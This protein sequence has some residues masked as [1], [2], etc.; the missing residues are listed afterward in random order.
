MANDEVKELPEE[1][2]GSPKKG[3]SRSFKIG[4]FAVIFIIAYILIHS[5]GPSMTVLD[6][7]TNQKFTIEKSTIEYSTPD[8]AMTVGITKTSQ[9]NGQK[10]YIAILPAANPI[11]SISFSWNPNGWNTQNYDP[12]NGVINWYSK[13]PGAQ[14]QPRDYNNGDFGGAKGTVPTQ[15]GDEYVCIFMP[16]KYL[17]VMIS[18][19]N[20][21]L[22]NDLIDSISIDGSKS[23]QS[24][25]TSQTSGRT[26][27]SGAANNQNYPNSGSTANSQSLS[28]A[29]A[30]L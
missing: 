10:I 3:M 4:I 2:R 22:F 27:Q 1:K 26:R 13:K 20:A 29:I 6:A 15:S 18:S 19:K 17:L 16:N 7:S 5:G 12:A 8:A 25:Q 21:A 30:N 24:G 11:A 23:S 9:E 28:D 14:V